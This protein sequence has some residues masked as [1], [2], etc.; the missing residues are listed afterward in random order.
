MKIEI[1]KV[2]IKDAQGILDVLNP[3]I[4][5]QNFSSMK[6]E[7]TLADQ[8][9]FIQ[10]LPS[11]AIYNLA[12]DLENLEIVGIQDI[13]PQSK[14]FNGTG[15]ISTFVNL[16]YH[17]QGIGERLMKA[18]LREAKD[19]GYKKIQAIIR[20]DNRIAI[21]FYKKNGF[22]EMGSERIFYE[23]NLLKKARQ[24]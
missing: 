10:N 11:N 12:F 22:R 5:T 21:S 2:K 23:L 24:N 20:T 18:T 13:L 8:T 17:R 9:N 14:N 16:N 3:I 4:K 19:L 1:R 6:E 15:E 7:N